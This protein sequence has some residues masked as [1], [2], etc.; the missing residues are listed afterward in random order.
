MNHYVTIRNGLIAGVVIILLG[1]GAYVY[2]FWNNEISGNPEQW[3]QLGDYMNFFVSIASLI[4]V[5]TL[6]YT[7]HEIQ[8]ER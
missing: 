1:F 8:Q 4:V 5:A 3:G 2:R 6:T 7:L